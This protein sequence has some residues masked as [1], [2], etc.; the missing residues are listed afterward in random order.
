MSPPEVKICAHKKWNK[1]TRNIVLVFFVSILALPSIDRLLV[2]GSNAALSIPGQGPSNPRSE[3]SRKVYEIT[4]SNPELAFEVQLKSVEVDT[5]AIEDQRPFRQLSESKRISRFLL[6]TSVIALL[7]LISIRRRSSQPL[8]IFQDQLIS[9]SVLWISVCTALTICTYTANSRWDEVFVFGSQAEN[10]SRTWI[11]FVSTTGSNERAESSADFLSTVVAGFIKKLFHNLNIETCLVL[12][13]LGLAFLFA[14]LIIIKLHKWWSLHLVST[15]ILMAG[16]LILPPHLLSLAAGFPVIVANLSFAFLVLLTLYSY[17]SNDLRPLAG[18]SLFLGLVRWEYGIVALLALFVG[19]L[20]CQDRRWK[21]IFRPVTVA[22][23]LQLGIAG[24]RTLVYGHPVPTGIVLKSSGLDA[25][26]VANGIQ[27][28]RSTSEVG[29]WTGIGIFGTILLLVAPVKSRNHVGA[30]LIAVLPLA[31][32][33]L[34]GGDWFPNHWARYAMP[35]A[36]ALFLVGYQLIFNPQLIN[37]L[38]K[39]TFNTLLLVGILVAFS[40][41]GYGVVA[42]ELKAGK[43]IGRTEC[44]ARAGTTLRSILPRDVGIATAEVNTLAYFA[45]QP[46]TDLSGI[47]DQRIAG[48]PPS[49]ITPGDVMHRKS[50]PGVIESDNPGAIYLWEGASCLNLGQGSHGES[51]IERFKTEWASLLD[52]EITR[53]RAGSPEHLLR[54]Y[55]PVTI[56]NNLG[57]VLHVLIRKDLVN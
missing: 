54:R 12:G 38:R 55:F 24:L 27:Y 3:W 51:D 36:I 19:V 6:L 13:N 32:S 56:V 2:V 17:Q 26:Y 39:A 46:L 37:N 33:P 57:D 1:P 52:N 49:P 48:A 11:P 14:S 53:F 35:T 22:V 9:L 29:S 4:S 40:T 5:K 8:P 15:S 10:V 47:V 45:Q 30:A 31:M 44:L 7:V 20:L 28:L 50:N 43:V 25:S 16:F 21:T 41:Y 18:W 34:S 23:F 42:G